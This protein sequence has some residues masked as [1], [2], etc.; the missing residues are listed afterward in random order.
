MFL[1]SK[2]YIQLKV[3]FTDEIHITPIAAKQEIKD[4]VRVIASTL[5][6]ILNFQ[7]KAVPNE[8]KEIAVKE[9]FMKKGWKLEN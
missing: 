1:A 4:S 9:Y 6:T 5:S 3:V 7:L 2:E 8:K